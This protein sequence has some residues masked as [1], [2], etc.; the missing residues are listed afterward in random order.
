NDILGVEN[1][2]KK[3]VLNVRECDAVMPLNDTVDYDAFRFRDMYRGLFKSSEGKTDIV[4]LDVRTTKVFKPV[5]LPQVI[6][7]TLARL[8][9]MGFIQ[10]ILMGRLFNLLFYILVVYFAIRLMPVFRTTLAVCG[11]LPMAMQLAGNFSYDTFITAVSFLLIG[12]VFNLTYK[13]EKITL[14]D[15]VLPTAAMCLLA[16]VKAIYVVMGLLAFMLPSEKFPDRKKAMPAKAAMFAAVLIFWSA[17]NLSSVIGVL[18]PHRK[19]APAQNTSPQT[20]QTA[21]PA[22]TEP[23]EEPGLLYPYDLFMQENPPRE[24]EIFWDPEGDLLPNG[25]SRHYYS[26]PYILKNLKQTVKLVLNTITKESG[27]YLQC[28]IGTRLGEI[29]AVDLQASWIWFILILLVL[30]LSVVQVRGEK[31]TKL[32]MGRWIGAFVFVALT[33]LTVAAC[34]MWTP[35]NYQVIFGIQGRYL[36]PAFPLIVIFLSNRLITLE[37]N[38]DRIL[39]YAMLPLNL[40]VVLNVFMIMCGY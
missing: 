37:K 32:G 5:Y 16:P 38:I 39:V 6:G 33:G 10:L 23:E 40:M 15:L 4:Q 18:K 26:V 12:S 7:I 14:K 22:E 20:T 24:E 34:I 1:T 8:L 27:K 9:D 29:I 30:L 21:P 19:K 3:K 28:I 13:K 11:L 2:G 25:D 35:I 31:K 17:T 36:V